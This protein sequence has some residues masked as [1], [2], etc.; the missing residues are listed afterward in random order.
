MHLIYSGKEFD[1]EVIIGIVV[2]VLVLLSCGLLGF[3]Y[4]RRAKQKGYIYSYIYGHAM[5]VL[6][7]SISSLIKFRII[8]IEQKKTR[9]QGR[10]FCISILTVVS[11]L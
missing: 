6:Y 2:P 10:I 3:F 4:N 1:L 7:I 11:A 8:H 9:N 5:H